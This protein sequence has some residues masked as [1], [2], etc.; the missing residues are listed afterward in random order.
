MKVCMHVLS[1]ALPDAR[2]MREAHAL[3]EAGMS[4]TIVDIEHDPARG[5]SETVDGVRFEHAQL[6]QR[7]RKHY[8]PLRT[9]P[10]LVFKGVRI[11]RSAWK[12]LACRADA[13]HAHDLTALPACYF[14]ARLRR[15]RLIFDAHELPLVEPHVTRHRAMHR[16]L[17]SM[18]R[19]MVRRC[20][21]VIT[22]SAPIANELHQRY[23]GP[24][25]VVVRNILPYQA[26]PRSE[27]L[28]QRLG[29]QDC[30]AI[31]LYQGVLGRDRSLEIIVRAGQYLPS[32][33]VIVLM[34]A[35][36]EEEGLRRLID[37]EGLS[38]RVRLIPPVPYRDLLTWTASA[39]VGLAIFRPE[40]SPSIRYCLPNKL[41]E[42][43]MAGVPVIAS[44]MEAVAEILD[45]YQVG[46][47]LRSLE[48]SEVGRAI[49][50]LLADGPLRAQM[51]RNALAA[52]QHELRWEVER[53]TL[54]RLYASLARRR[55]SEV[56]SVGAA[57]H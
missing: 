10:W 12:V 23:G 40:Y 5:R 32:G 57:A 24:V 49:A 14:A 17:T 41:F 37:W 55:P 38:D 46:I 29:L 1:P 44:S 47:T 36:P 2:V 39:D 28:R 8:S 11:A 42:Y 43:L 20:S 50:D 3:V 56:V 22:V 31:A 34:G 54:V 18:L 33:A 19:R 27:V 52:S 35:G 51:R 6:S 53:E 48:P 30:A 16:L 7:S 25:P 15:K 9:L 45:Q 26:P 4:V 21:A 13:Y